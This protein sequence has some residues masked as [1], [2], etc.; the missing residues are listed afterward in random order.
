MAELNPQ[1][2]AAVLHAHGPMLVLAGAGSGKTRVITQKIAHLIDK[3]G[4]DAR[5][6]FAVTFTN[7]AASEMRERVAQLCQGQPTRGLTVSTFHSLGLQIL[8][9]EIHRLGYKKA[10]SILDA[11]DTVAL[12]RDLLKDNQDDPDLAE[13]IQGRISRFKNAGLAPEA[14]PLEGDPLHSR[15]ARL[16]PFYQRALKAYSAVDF[17]DLIS[18]PNQ[19][20]AHDA[21]ARAHWQERVRYLLVDE[22]QDTNSAQYQ[23]IKWLLGMRRNLT[24]V[25]DDDQSI[26]AWRG[27][28]AENLHR[29]GQDFPDLNV[30]KLEQNYRSTGRILTA[31][32]RLIANN[33]HL[34][35]KQL[36]STLGHGEP[37]R[38]VRCDDETHEAEK[39]VSLL[40]A[41][42]FQRQARFSD[43]AILYR[44]NHQAR[45]FETALRAA[46]VP[47]HLTGGT[48]FFARGEIKDLMAYLR[49]LVNPDDDL[50]FLRAVN[51]PRR[52][53]GGTTLEA[54]GQFAQKRDKSLFE[55]IWEP[56]LG[57][58]LPTRALEAL[59]GFGDWINRTNE[60]IDKT[61]TTDGELAAELRRLPDAIDYPGYLRDQFDERG[62]SRRLENINSLFDSVQRM[63]ETEDG[64]RSL[65]EILGRLSLFSVLERQEE[66][67]GDEVRLMTLHAAKGLEFP[68]VFLVG[69]E[70]GFLPHRNSIDSDNIEEE[71]RLAYV[72]LTR[73]QFLLVL[74]MA[75][76]RRRYGE[77]I[78]GE[79]SRF[80]SELPAEDLR[81][82][83]E[84]NSEE[85]RQAV[86]QGTLAQLRQMLGSK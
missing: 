13:G 49:L 53:I 28:E 26:Y 42:K 64:P 58:H 61:T 82:E 12:V 32:N 85:Q 69:M 4:V 34:Y 67:G 62:A 35:E 31:A 38:V 30:I 21:E 60:Q 37:I 7:K 73:A 41:E 55:A 63:L 81:W 11:S 44:G 6:I 56:D 18:L 54:L 29:L 52:G 23:L 74:T 57:E 33:P 22:Y 46:R 65:P 77:W 14:V 86:A 66:E 20:F 59:R 40:L 78:A 75:R 9:Q 79:P 47:Y 5:H 80:L 70:E 45:A 51:T 8:R 50:A 71:R 76:K 2:Q 3:H 36:W 16:Y 48:S 72:G 24:A 83:G 1:Q 84:N 68:Y 10:F 43:F 25:G 39:V 19:L 27:A 17:D 15:A